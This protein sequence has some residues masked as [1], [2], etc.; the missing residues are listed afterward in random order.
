MKWAK[1]V[2]DPG[3]ERRKET[4]VE[5][6]CFRYITEGDLK[7]HYSVWGHYEFSPELK[8]TPQGKKNYELFVGGYLSFYDDRVRGGVVDHA[9][10]LKWEKKDKVSPD[11]P[12]V[13]EV[14][15][16]VTIFLHPKPLIK[17][18]DPL[19]LSASMAQS[20]ATVGQHQEL[21]SANPPGDN[22][23]LSIDPPPPPPPPPPPV[24]EL[25]S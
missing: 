13:A 11:H 14:Y 16:S 19:S 5:K 25:S 10:Y 20:G 17:V 3:Q 6:E 4:Q 22:S 7:T 21:L 8:I 2:K 23:N 24:D 1:I 15:D 18:H 9:I 12:N